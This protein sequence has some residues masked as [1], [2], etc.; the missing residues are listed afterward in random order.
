MLGVKS[1]MTE[2]ELVEWGRKVE[3][4][5]LFVLQVEP[6]VAH[7]THCGDLIRTTY[8]PSALRQR[9]RRAKNL[10]CSNKCADTARRKS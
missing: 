6:L 2:A 9:A 3:A 5:E 8:P 10:Y 7:C 1:T 4:N